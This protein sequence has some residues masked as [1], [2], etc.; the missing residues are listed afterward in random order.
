[1]SS[2]NE[3]LETVQLK[4][5]SIQEFNDWKEKEELATST[6]YVQHRGSKTNMDKTVTTKYYCHRSGV[7]KSKSKGERSLNITGS[8]KIDQ[9][10]PSFIRTVVGMINIEVTYCKT[11]LGHQ[12]E[13]RFLPI[14][15][16][17]QETI[18]GKI[19]SGIPPNVIID[20]FRNETN[21]NIEKKNIITR[22]DIYNI[23]AQFGLLHKYKL[24]DVDAISVD[25]QVKRFAQNS[26]KS[27]NPIIL[28]K[29]QG[30]EY[31]PLEKDD[32]MIIILTETQKAV[33][34]KFSSEKLCIDATH[35]TN[36]Y[37]FNL[38]TI[39]VIDEFGEGYPAAFCISSKIDE[40]HM[41]VFFSKIKEVTG[42]L[43]PNVF[44][45]DDAPAF[46][47]AWIK[48][49]SPIPKFHL[50]C[51]WH[52]DNN[53]RKNLKKIDGSLT[54][55]AYVYKTLR[56]L[57]EE[58]DITEFEN[59]LSS[60][61]CKLEE[62]PAMH[63]FKAYFVSTY[64]HRKKLWAAC[65]RRQAMINT[66]MVL[67]AFHKTLKHVYLKGKKNQ[68]LDALLWHLLK[69]VRDKNFERLVKLCNGGK[70][71][72]F[73]NVINSRHRSAL[74]TNYKVIK[75][76]DDTWSVA[77]N[78]LELDYLI[79][80]NEPCS[81]KVICIV[82]KCCVHLFSCTCYDYCIK[83]NMCKHIHVVRMNSMV[84]NEDVSMN[85]MDVIC[86][87]MANDEVCMK[88]PAAQQLN[89]PSTESINNKIQQLYNMFV[90]QAGTLDEQQLQ[91][92]NL[93]VDSSL[94]VLYQQ[95][96]KCM[97]DVEY[98]EPANKNID[99]QLRFYSTKKPRTKAP[100]EQ[101]LNRPTIKVIKQ[102]KSD[103]KGNED[104]PYVNIDPH[105]EHSYGQFEQKKK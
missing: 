94:K 40:V 25:L 104:T 53:W 60:F 58:S 67:E 71:T 18:A 98:R 95:E 52:I 82:C 6:R 76:S 57:L 81:C 102:I 78:S 96:S 86:N 34:E 22:K 44:M 69:V 59:L 36:Q 90:S 68:R 23:S 74:Q 51:K 55:K 75:I 47:N 63:N 28:Y 88:M 66:N 65:Y 11:H 89:V 39:V 21:Y 56:V 15:T 105:F 62:E 103:L 4:F 26:N 2:S 54:T 42:S 27:L 46:W 73:V 70:V 10:C 9:Y 83:N 13:I 64:V 12:N 17:V 24:H 19:E 14:S 45:S 87:P 37:N 38:T 80:Q 8:C 31:F 61:L 48:I 93:T 33:L 35:G 84:N 5:G 100:E 49:M 43:T 20:Q 92:I 79:K 1:M 99:K 77:S 30:T 101:R 41:T 91:T 32:F 29:T 97:N 7:F 50:L 72:H 3:Q 85:S 16:V